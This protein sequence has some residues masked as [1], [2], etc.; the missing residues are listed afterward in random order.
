MNETNYLNFVHCFNRLTC[1]T[2]PWW[3]NPY[4]NSVTIITGAR[5]PLM[6]ALYALH[7]QRLDIHY[8]YACSGSVTYSHLLQHQY[9][10]LK[11]S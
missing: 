11:H 5:L 2:E 4:L 9:Q 1:C 3:G 6:M 10:L 7:V 8:Y